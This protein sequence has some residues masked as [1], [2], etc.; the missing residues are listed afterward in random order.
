MVEFIFSDDGPG[1]PE[2]SLDRIFE[3][4]YR[5]DGSRSNSGE[6]SGIGLAVVKEIIAG[7]RGIFYRI[8]ICFISCYNM[9]MILIFISSQ[10]GK[11]ETK[12]PILQ[13]INEFM[14]IWRRFL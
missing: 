4:F 6:G 5:V 9:G 13:R 1:V 14:H 11:E 10:A 7:H 12:W 2:E 8:V 3:S